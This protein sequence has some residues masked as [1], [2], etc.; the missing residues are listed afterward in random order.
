MH[1]TY[2]CIYFFLKYKVSVPVFVFITFIYFFLF[3][4]VNYTGLEKSKLFHKAE[5]L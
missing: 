1:H 5:R 2:V 3:R 4:F